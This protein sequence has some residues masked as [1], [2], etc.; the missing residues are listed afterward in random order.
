MGVADALI[1]SV[2]VPSSLKMVQGI[3]GGHRVAYLDDRYVSPSPLLYPSP[4]PLPEI[5]YSHE[6]FKRGRNTTLEKFAT[7]IISDRGGHNDNRLST[8]VTLS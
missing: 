7:H 6:L 5:N 1:Y 2:A 3:V 4:S 8:N